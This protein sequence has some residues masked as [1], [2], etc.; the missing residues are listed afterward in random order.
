MGHAGTRKMQSCKTLHPFPCPT[1][2]TSLAASANL[3][4]PQTCHLVDEAAQALTVARNGVVIQPPLN[5]TSQPAAG[6]TERAMSAF[7]QLL[8][9]LLKRST[10]T[11]GNRLAMNRQPAVLLR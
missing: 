1:T 9:D 6:F 10:H 8:F 5:N 3:R 2:A 4:Q 11:L 7:L